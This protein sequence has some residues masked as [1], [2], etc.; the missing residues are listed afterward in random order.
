MN[1]TLEVILSIA[2][3]AVFIIGVFA[4]SWHKI[5]TETIRLLK[6]QNDEL[7]SDRTDSIQKLANMQG[8]INT[9]KSVPLRELADYRVKVDNKLADLCNGNKQ[10]IKMLGQKASDSS[11]HGAT[12]KV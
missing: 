2:G 11:Q 1:Q 6:E 3:V 7:K 10:I 12:I 8:Q 5:Q 4:L 9:L